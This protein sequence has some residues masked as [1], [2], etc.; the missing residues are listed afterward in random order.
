M[1]IEAPTGTDTRERDKAPRELL[2]LVQGAAAI[3][4]GALGLKRAEEEES[5]GTASRF[6][7]YELDS[8]YLRARSFI[9]SDW[10]FDQ[11][12]AVRENYGVLAEILGI[13]RMSC[14]IRGG[15]VEEISF[16]DAKDS[17]KVWRNEHT[18]ECMEEAISLLELALDSIKSSE[19]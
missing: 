7:E 16:V 17:S 9:G 12:G 6:V 1:S 14:E 5:Y 15:R 19:L 18:P 3:P 4:R 8:V 11:E 2:E 10:D 13:G